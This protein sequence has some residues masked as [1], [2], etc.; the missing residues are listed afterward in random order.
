MLD[1][2]TNGLDLASRER[3]E[4]ALA[5]YPGTLILV[6]HDRYLVQRLADRILHIADGRLEL[7]RGTYAEYAARGG[8][9]KA[10]D[11]AE[12]ILLLETRLAQ[13]SAALAAPPEGEAEA[14]EQEFIRVS[15]ALRALKEKRA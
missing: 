14:L 11:A 8:T 1:E 6:S 15:R 10:P 12:E 2:P 5:D 4:E 13:L 9:E 3:V 7:F